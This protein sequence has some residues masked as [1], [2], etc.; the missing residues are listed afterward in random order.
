M[1]PVSATYLEALTG[2]HRMV[3]RCKLCTPSGQIGTNP[4]GIELPIIGGN[5]QFD[6]TADVRATLSLETNYPWPTSTSDAF[7][8]YGSE[9]FVERGVV[10]GD[11]TREW[12]SLGYFRI[13]DMEQ[14]EAPY[15]NV[16]V[17]AQDRM[18]ALIEA[19]ILVPQQFSAGVDAETVYN[20]LILPILPYASPSY[21]FT[22]SLK[23][24]AG[25]HILEEDRYKF[26]LEL[27][28]SLGKIMFF[29]YD[30]TF[31]VESPP[32]PTIPLWRIGHGQRGV[33]VKAKRALTRKGVYNAVVVTGDRVGEG[34]N[35][36]IRQY[37]VDTDP[38]SPTYFYGT[39]GQVPKYFNSSFIS[40]DAQALSAAQAMVIRSKGLPY[41]VDLTHIPNSALEV[42]D[43]V[44]VT[45]GDQFNPEIHVLDQMSIPLTPEVAMTGTSRK[46]KDGVDDGD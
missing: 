12:V 2:S 35:P 22:P 13:T 43:P 34:D 8:P 44:L 28:E 11:G 33:L 36:P 32:N 40:T 10:Y 14:D 46:V 45:Y 5:V 19:R 29:D 1:R 31:R 24:W 7:N 27:T 9:I 26:L 42:L 17:T 37:A 38:T 25:N 6:A 21:D 3:A 20:S 41:N 18:S 39:F 30:G 23:S 15:G 16:H 4:N